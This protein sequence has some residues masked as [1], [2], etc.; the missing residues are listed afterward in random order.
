VSGMMSVALAVAVHGMVGAPRLPHVSAY[1]PMLAG[2]HRPLVMQQQQPEDKE[3]WY[4]TGLS[5]GRKSWYGRLAD[6]YREGYQRSQAYFRSSA[7]NAPSSE[8][9]LRQSDAVGALGLTV[10]L[11]EAILFGCSCVLAWLS[12]AS[13]TFAM[14]PPQ[15]RLVGAA[16]KAVSF[17][18]ASRLPRLVVESVTLPLVQAQVRARPVSDRATFVKDRASQTVAVVVVVL[19][20]LRAFN[21][22]LLRGT[23]APAALELAQL[24]GRMLGP[25]PSF[26]WQ[27][28]LCRSLCHALHA[29]W[30]WTLDAGTRAVALDTAA[31]R[32][33]LLGPLYSMAELECVMAGPARFVSLAMVAFVDD[34]VKPILRTLG[35][36][37]VQTLA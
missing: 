6:S 1:R 20:T 22:R 5:E 9:P 26:L 31:R 23:A 11:V 19:L 35:F 25:L 4:A 37:T 12:T 8:E 32:S 27:F 15:A 14:G 7:G 34:V 17:R 13:D 2:Y 10:I 3:P 36:I 18:S 28:P 16:A 33:W 24:T 21:A 30:A 29:A